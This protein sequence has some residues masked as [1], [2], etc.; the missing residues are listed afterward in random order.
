MDAWVGAQES[1]GDSS[2]KKQLVQGES[3]YTRSIRATQTIKTDLSNF[4]RGRRDS[5]GAY[6]ILIET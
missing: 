6:G 1:L 2:S 4:F 5:K 3:T